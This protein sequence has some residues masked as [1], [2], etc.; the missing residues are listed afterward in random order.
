MKTAGCFIFNF[1]IEREIMKERRRKG[2]KE[3]KGGRKNFD[4]L[5]SKKKKKTFLA[6]ANFVSVKIIN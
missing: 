1:N 6:K 4:Q 2:R 5:F 3:T